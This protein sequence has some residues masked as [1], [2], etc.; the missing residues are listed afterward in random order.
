MIALM[1]GVWG[2]EEAWAGAGAR[3][4]GLGGHQCGSEA[5]CKVPVLWQ[6]GRKPGERVQASGRRRAGTCW[7]RVAEGADEGHRQVREWEW[8]PEG[9]ETRK[10]EDAIDR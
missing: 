6:G 4:R 8:R 7:W 5:T 10:R 9:E 3:C 2:G 1:G